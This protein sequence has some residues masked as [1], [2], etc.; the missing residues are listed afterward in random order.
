MNGNVSKYLDTHTTSSHEQAHDPW[1]TFRDSRRTPF[2]WKNI[3]NIERVQSI[4]RECREAMKLW[5]YKV[6]NNDTKLSKFN[7]LLNLTN[8]LFYR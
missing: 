6:A 1:T 5:G 8:K 2:E 4:Q 3:L 7:P